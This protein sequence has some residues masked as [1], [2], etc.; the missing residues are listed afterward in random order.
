MSRGYRKQNDNQRE[1]E[2]NE[3]EK[4]TISSFVLNINSQELSVANLATLLLF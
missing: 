2:G 1:S 4:G 3:G